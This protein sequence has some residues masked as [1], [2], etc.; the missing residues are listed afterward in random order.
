MPTDK[1]YCFGDGYAHGHIWPEWP[2]LLEALFPT[3][4]IT[5]VSGI[6]AGPEYLVTQF[7]RMLPINGPVIFQWPIANRFDKV[8][9]DEYWTQV[10]K[11]DPVYSFNIYKQD[12]ETWWLSSASNSPEVKEYSAKY[13]QSAQSAIR[14]AVYQTL[15]KE[16]LEKTGHNYIFTTTNEQDSF[17]K[18]NLQLRGSEI[19][20]SPL[21]HFYFL[22][23]KLLPKLGLHSDNIELLEQLLL[24]QKWMPYDP[25]RQ[26]I[27]NNIKHNLTTIADK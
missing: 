13:I 2:Q 1:I 3:Y 24:A 9:Q 6:G 21:S 15:V 4:E 10:A 25:D 11:N 12:R 8:I 16:I 7:S 22:T 5:V 20:P 27:W 26:E 23:E 18:S 19:Q 14:L 17:S